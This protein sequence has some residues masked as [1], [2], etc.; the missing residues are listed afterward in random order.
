MLRGHVT[1][2]DLG[3]SPKCCGKPQLSYRDVKV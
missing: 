2:D 3:L 1:T